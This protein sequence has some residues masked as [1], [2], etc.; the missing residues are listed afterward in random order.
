M[1]KRCKS[2]VTDLD[3]NMNINALTISEM[4]WY[5]P[6]QLPFQVNGFAWFEMEEKYRRLPNRPKE[7]ISEQVDHLADCT[8]GGQIRFQTN[9]T[10]L[11]IRVKLKDKANLNHMSALSQ[12]G[13]D[14]YIGKPGKQQ[15]YNGT[16]Y[17]H[18]QNFYEIL[19]FERENNCIVNITLNFPLYQGVE[20]V[21]IGLD[22]SAQVISPL[23]HN[24]LHKI[25]FYGTS[26]T[27]GGCASRPGLSYTNIISR[28]LNQE[29]INLGF[30]GNGK[31]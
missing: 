18:S 17:D 22:Q 1:E 30:F 2:V 29:C 14:C 26:I 7:P 10:K 23:K 28:R 12:C 21:Q 31:V 13:F 25:I 16:L 6:K 4:K 11:A 8:S 27:Q 3:E 9:S 15:F 19:L 24:R 20:Q 5:D